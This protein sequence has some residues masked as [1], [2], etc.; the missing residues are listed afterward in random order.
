MMYSHQNEMQLEQTYK[1]TGS[2]S[3]KKKPIKR[4]KFLE[5]AATAILLI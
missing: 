1:T 3:K 2:D 4:N 5:F